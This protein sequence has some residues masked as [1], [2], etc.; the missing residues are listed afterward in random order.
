MKDANQLI[1]NDAKSIVQTHLDRLGDTMDS[2]LDP[3]LK[4]ENFQ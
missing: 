3:G 4:R 1:A 2:R